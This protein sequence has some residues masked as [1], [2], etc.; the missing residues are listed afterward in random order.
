MKD[1]GQIDGK[2]ACHI[3]ENKLVVWHTDEDTRLLELDDHDC[4]ETYRWLNL[5]EIYSV[6]CL[7]DCGLET[8]VM[9]SP[10]KNNQLTLLKK[11]LKT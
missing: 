8:Y 11:A 4:R 3:G 9:V 1:Y 7:D 5:T 10:N 2:G 6:E